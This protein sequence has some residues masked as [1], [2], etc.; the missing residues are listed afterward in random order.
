MSAD[1]YP[2]IFSRQMEAIV[3]IINK[4]FYLLV[5]KNITF[6]SREAQSNQNQANKET[7]IV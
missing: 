5:Y 1:K 4:I 7:K 6:R 2:S 3:Y